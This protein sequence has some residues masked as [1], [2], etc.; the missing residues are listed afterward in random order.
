MSIEAEFG[1][2]LGEAKGVE[3]L[4]VLPLG[5]PMLTLEWLD[6]IDNLGDEG[7]DASCNFMMDSLGDAIVSTAGFI[8][9]LCT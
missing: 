8:G 5:S 1:G 2:G 6:V 9:L 4:V 7:G 3:V